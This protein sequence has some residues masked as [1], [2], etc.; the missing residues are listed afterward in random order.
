MNPQFDY[1]FELFTLLIS[2]AVSEMLMGFSRILKMRA[3]RKAGVDPTAISVRVGWLVPLL[4]LLVG[5]QLLAAARN[6]SVRSL[7]C[8]SRSNRR[9]DLGCCSAQST[10]HPSSSASA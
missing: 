3:R 10:R 5:A 6:Y 9:P 8:S 4:G 1:I 7:N 2:L